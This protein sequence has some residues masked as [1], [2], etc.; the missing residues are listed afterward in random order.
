MTIQPGQEDRA[1]LAFGLSDAA[2]AVDTLIA[3]HLHEA[4][5]CSPESQYPLLAH[6]HHPEAG[7]S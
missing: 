2:L 1:V 7:E 3:L 6:W 5:A 4:V